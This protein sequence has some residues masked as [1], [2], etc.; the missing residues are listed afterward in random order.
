M[1]DLTKID[2]A[3]EEDKQYHIDRWAKLFKAD[4]WEELRMVAS[5]DEAL[6]EAA[7]TLFYQSSDEEIRKI[8]RAH[9]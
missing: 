3:T 6:Y 5:E 7:K 1:A 2:L 4:T 8:G 9:V